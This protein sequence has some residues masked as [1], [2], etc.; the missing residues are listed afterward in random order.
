MGASIGDPG[1]PPVVLAS[2]LLPPVC[3]LAGLVDHSQTA[4]PWT[5]SGAWTVYAVWAP[6]AAVLAV[7]GAHRRDQ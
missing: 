7:A 1:A 5:T 6:A 4:F 2:A 3:A